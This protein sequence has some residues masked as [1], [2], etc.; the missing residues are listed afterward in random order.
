MWNKKIIYFVLI[1][2]SVIYMIYFKKYFL[3]LTVI[4]VQIILIR[5]SKS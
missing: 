4:V 5:R 1:G 3:P 2:L